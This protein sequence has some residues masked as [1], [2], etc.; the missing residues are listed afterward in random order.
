[1]TI[2]RLQVVTEGVSTWVVTL[3]IADISQPPSSV[4]QTRK[5]EKRDIFGMSA[6]LVQN[7][8]TW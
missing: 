3:Q 4:R 2:H 8:V 1:M 6:G 7:M 5:K